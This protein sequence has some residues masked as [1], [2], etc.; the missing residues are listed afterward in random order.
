MYNHR[1]PKWPPVGTVEG[2]ATD[3]NTGEGVVGTT[4][5]A[6]G[7][8]VTVRSTDDCTEV[9]PSPVSETVA[10]LVITLAGV[11]PDTVTGMVMVPSTG[12]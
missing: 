5:G 7:A 1:V 2:T 12:E 3:G 11:L 9:A 10:V 6:A 8:A 4:E